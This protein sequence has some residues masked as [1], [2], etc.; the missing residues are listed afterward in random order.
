LRNFITGWGFLKILENFFIKY[1]NVIISVEES[2]AKLQQV[3][4]KRKVD[5]IILNSP[6]FD[7]KFYENVERN[8]ERRSGDIKII[9][10]GSISSRN[11]LDLIINELCEYPHI[12]FHIYGKISNDYLKEFEEYIMTAKL[13]SNGRIQYCGILDYLLLPYKLLDYDF[14]LNCYDNSTINTKYAS[15]AKIFEYMKSG[16]GII[17]SDQ[18]T[19]KKIVSSC[20]NGIVFS[21]DNLTYLNNSLFELSKEPQRIID[22]KKNSLKHYVNTYSFDIQANELINWI[23]KNIK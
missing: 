3:D 1:P 16:L 9:Y 23:C 17:T 8:I 7:T 10:T 20:Q 18:P 5:W 21:V 4:W 6:T 13:I 14:G 12:T 15:P 2:R 19:P 22:M 11:R